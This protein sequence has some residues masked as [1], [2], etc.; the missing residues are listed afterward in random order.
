MHIR[1]TQTR[2]KLITLLINKL[3]W[4]NQSSDL[5]KYQIFNYER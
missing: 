3:L 4:Q 2:A 1:N 5:G